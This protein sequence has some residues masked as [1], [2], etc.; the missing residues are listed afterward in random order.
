MPLRLYNT[1]TRQKED[2]VPLDPSNVTY[3]NCGPTVYDAFTI[4]NARN[5]I[6]SDTLRRYLQASGYKVTFAQNLTDVDDKIIKRAR[7]EGK[8]AEE[9]ANHYIKVY[10][11]YADALGI[12]R[13]TVHPRCAEYIPQMIDAIGRLIEKGH[14]YPS[15]GDVF[16]DVSSYKDYGRLSRKKLDEMEEAGRVGEQIAERK[17]ASADFALWKGAKPGEPQWESPWG[18]GR[19]GWH[20][21]CSVMSGKTLGDTIDLHSGGEDLAFPHHE[22]EIAQSCCLTGKEF[23]RF[24][25]HNAF[26]NFGDKISKSTMTAEM[27]QLFMIDKALER[28]KP[29]AIRYFFMTAHYRSPLQF[30][31]E[32]MDE[33]QNRCDKIRQSCEQAR[34]VMQ[35][36]QTLAFEDSSP[37]VAGILVKRFRDAMDDDLNTPQALAVLA[38]A[39]S[40]LNT[41]RAEIDREGPAASPE[42][43]SELTSVYQVIG[44]FLDIL[45]L[46]GFL[47]E[48]PRGAEGRSGKAELILKALMDARLQARAEKNW[49]FSDR[50]RD[51][52]AAAG[53]ALKDG[54][55]GAT[56]TAEKGLPSDE[57]LGQMARTAL[58]RAAGGTAET[59][60]GALTRLGV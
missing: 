12:Q 4:G 20:I 47:Y 28:F 21:E 18:P 39:V 40:R 31:L 42:K 25:L 59:L 3:Y 23:A 54:A 14:A 52:L 35:T 53:V 15:G 30:S 50:V 56:W 33:A 19:P 2:F 36:E 45:G 34:Q 16:F 26:L 58:E 5:F 55:S 24:W 9:V 29:E 11:Q 37:A 44:D 1:L 57:A 41:L 49:A 32:A 46:R 51:D 17:R 10:F 22:N 48:P 27:R 13:A 6:F 60:R 7:E 38:E 43:H 8:T